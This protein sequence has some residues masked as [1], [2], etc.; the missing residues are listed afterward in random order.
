MK[1]RFVHTA[2]ICIL[3]VC[4]CCVIIN[5][6]EPAALQAAANTPK[7]A[8]TENKN[9]KIEPIIMAGIQGSEPQSEL[10]LCGGVQEFV[11]RLEPIVALPEKESEYADFAIANVSRYV[12]VRKEPNT[13][14]EIV[15]KIYNGAVAHVLS[16]AGEDNDW[17]Q[18]ISG[19]VEGYI[20]AE[21]FFYGEEAAAVIDDY[22]TRYA[23]VQAS[24]LNV[25]KEPDINSKRIGFINNGERVKLLENQ[26]EWL[27]VQYA[28]DSTGYV[29]AEYVMIVEEFVYAKTLEEEAAELAA[30]KA[31]EARKQVS[32]QQAAENTAIT[33]TPPAQSYSSNEELRSQ[34]I[35]YSMQFVGNK[36]VHGGQTLSG[37]TDCSGFTSLIYAQFGYSLSRTPGGQLS[38]AGRSVDYSNAQPGDIICYGSG[39]T[40]THV[41]LYLG[42]GQIIHSANPRKGVVTQ[43]AGFDTIIGVKSVVD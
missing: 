36:Y 2:C 17:F 40:C 29:A 28:G 24:R 43:A 13:D 4:L 33:V 3:T 22:V 35:E 37:G 34:I 39:Q 32:E 14:S 18:M 31:Q 42:D 5:A 19:N 9:L 23:V 12:N 25:R 11:N 20:K 6:K 26:G 38:G 16:A 15:G 21:Y 1:D 41:A 8:E 27:K 30:K 10:L 7:I